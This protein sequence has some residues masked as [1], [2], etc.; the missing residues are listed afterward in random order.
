MKKYLI[1]MTDI[2]DTWEALPPSEQERIFGLHKDFEAALRREGRF[3]AGYHLHPRC[4]ARTVRQSEDGSQTTSDGPYSD[5]DEYA[6]GFYVILAESMEEA[7]DWARKSRFV[8][9]ANEVR[10][11]F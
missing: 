9:G 8:V 6:G 10:A 5:A 1:T 7:V 2:E 3:V 4:E 11:I